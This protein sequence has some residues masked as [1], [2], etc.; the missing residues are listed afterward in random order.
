ML[1]WVKEIAKKLEKDSTE[2]YLGVNPADWGEYKYN[3]GYYRGYSKAL[4]SVVE[5]YRKKDPED[6]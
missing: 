2:D 4:A 6:I 5:E 1:T 3:L